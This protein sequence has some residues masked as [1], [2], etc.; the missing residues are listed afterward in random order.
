E[1]FS[2]GGRLH[3]VAGSWESFRSA[4]HLQR[5][6]PSRLIDQDRL[7]GIVEQGLSLR[8]SGWRQLAGEVASGEEAEAEF[9]D[10]SGCGHS[11]KGRSR[12]ILGPSTCSATLPGL[13]SGTGMCFEAG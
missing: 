10:C 4:V 13:V 1:A 5:C 12:A 2:P 11:A 8:T 3:E 7:R 9:L 6:V